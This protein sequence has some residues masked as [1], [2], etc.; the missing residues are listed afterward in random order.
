M[1]RR[2]W[3]MTDVGRRAHATVALAERAVDLGVPVAGLDG[4]DAVRLCRLIN[5]YQHM[6]PAQ[7]LH[8]VAGPLNFATL[9]S[10]ELAE[11]VVEVVEAGGEALFAAMSFAHE[12]PAGGLPELGARLLPY[13]EQTAS[14]SQCE[15]AVVF[16][17]WARDVGAV[18][19][20]LRRLLLGRDLLLRLQALLTLVELDALSADDVQA[21]LEDAVV[22]P[23]PRGNGRWNEAAYHYA[24]ELARAVRRLRPPQ[25]Y[26]PLCAILRHE[27]VF[28]QYERYGVDDG[29][30]LD[31]LAAVWPERALEA[32]DHRLQARFLGQR[33]DA[34]RACGALPRHLA[35]ARLELAVS[36]EL[37]IVREA[38]RTAWK[39]CFCKE[40]P[41]Q[42]ELPIQVERRSDEFDAHLE[43]L[44]G[45]E[46]DPA[47]IAKL[48]A[49]APEREALALLLWVLQ[50]DAVRATSDL[51]RRRSEW[52]ELLIERFGDPAFDGL[53]LL[54]ERQALARV[55]NGWLQALVHLVKKP[56]FDSTRQKRLQNLAQ[57][58]LLAPSRC[59]VGR[60]VLRALQELGAPATC[61]DMLWALSFESD[62]V[63]RDATIRRSDNRFEA[64]EALQAVGPNDALDARVGRA[65]ATAL[66]AGELDV[67]CRLL[68]LAKGRR[69]ADLH[70]LAERA[71]ALSA[72]ALDSKPSRAANKLASGSLAALSHIEQLDEERLVGWLRDPETPLFTAAARHVRRQDAALL[73]LLRA[74]LDSSARG[75]TSAAVAAERLLSHGVVPPDNPILLPLLERLPPTALCELLATWVYLSD[76]HSPFAPHVVE[77]LC[78]DELSIASRGFDFAQM[79]TESKQTVLR[80]ALGRGVHTELR[81]RVLQA[82]DE[83]TSAELYFTDYDDA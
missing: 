27:C 12:R 37:P 54:A 16:A 1:V 24:F 59:G 45:R 2:V 42:I 58:L 62:E 80:Q 79:M 53:L 38:A 33:H 82:A 57:R 4:R 17:G 51:P 15:Q 64:I 8:D 69:I 19:P 44:S 40:C 49:R 35:Q 65:L 72:V 34:A 39:A 21:L 14:R 75:G 81:D 76:D 36:D 71:L 6:I 68:I 28:V 23:P 32:I 25:G 56:W 77:L 5:R 10:D 31:A 46:P 11:L 43:A 13:L 30:A 9:D 18:A 83:P 70:A 55:D 47:T 20:A 73:E 61:V 63:E 3:A 22:R 67:S 78:S 74:A 50:H 48:V 7:L 52:A 60:D 29:F 66:D 26:R 41:L